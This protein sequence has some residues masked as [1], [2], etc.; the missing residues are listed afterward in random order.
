MAAL[1]LVSFVIGD[2]GNVSEEC[3]IVKDCLP[4][5][6]EE[7]MAELVEGNEEGIIPCCDQTK[8]IFTCLGDSAEKCLLEVVGEFAAPVLEGE[9]FCNALEIKSCFVPV[10]SCGTLITSRCEETLEAGNPDEVE[11]CC[12]ELIDMVD[13]IG[14]DLTEQCLPD[15]AFNSVAAGLEKCVGIPTAVP[16]PFPTPDD[17]CLE[18]IAN[19]AS[20][21]RPQCYSAALEAIIDQEIEGLLPCCNEVASTLSCLEFNEVECENPIVEAAYQANLEILTLG[22]SICEAKPTPEPTSCEIV[23]DCGVFIRPTCLAAVLA[24]DEAVIETC[25]N[26]IGNYSECLGDLGKDCLP[27]SAINAL[28]AAEGVCDAS[29]S[30]SPVFLRFP[31]KGKVTYKVTLTWSWSSATHPNSYPPGGNISPFALVSHGLEYTLWAE[32][33]Y[34]SEGVQMVAETGAT[35]ALV[36]EL[37]AENYRNVFQRAVDPSGSSGTETRIYALE[38]HTTR[39]YLSGERRP[40]TSLLDEH[41]EGIPVGTYVIEK[42]APES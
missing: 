37:K 38:V 17:N 8:K 7:C 30:R 27:P 28:E 41:F 32:L 16:S 1:L 21:I 5:I 9:T 18:V 19:C 13:C 25:C 14:I 39:S 29:S 34:A 15:T 35:S 12:Q 3:G 22:Q 20:F 2:P 36:N 40:I 11:G 4:F 26:E 33:G 31:C 23:A 42:L 24:G 6:T 10:L